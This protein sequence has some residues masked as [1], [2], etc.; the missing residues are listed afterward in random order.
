M[1]DKP[2]YQIIIDEEEL[3]MHQEMLDRD[4]DDSRSMSYSEQPYTKR[5]EILDQFIYFSINHVIDLYQKAEILL[6]TQPYF[7]THITTRVWD[8]FQG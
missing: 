1:N 3:R 7:N 8:N 2:S 4:E 5:H 6:F